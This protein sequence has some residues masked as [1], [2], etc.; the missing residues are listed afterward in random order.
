MLPLYRNTPKWHY[1]C[2]YVYMFNELSFFSHSFDKDVESDVC[3]GCI[4]IK[5]IEMYFHGRLCLCPSSN[6]I[7]YP[8]HIEIYADLKLF[9]KL[10]LPPF[11][12]ILFPLSTSHVHISWSKDFLFCCVCIAQTKI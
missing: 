5:A 11:S 3:Y 12:F 6:Q 10:C 4:L 8:K 2:I 9:E 1:V 7:E